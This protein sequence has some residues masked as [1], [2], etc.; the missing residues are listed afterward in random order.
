MAQPCQ[1]TGQAW[2]IVL[3]HGPHPG[4]LDIFPFLSDLRAGLYQ[5]LTD[6]AIGTLAHET[7]VIVAVPTADGRRHRQFFFGKLTQQFVQAVAAPAEATRE[8]SI[9]VYTCSLAAPVIVCAASRVKLPRN[10]DS[11]LSTYCSFSPAA[12]TTN[13]RR[14]AYCGD[15]AP[16]RAIGP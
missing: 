1:S 15:A 2:H 7:Q 13:R 12:T 14:R 8:W 11:A 4:L 5:V 16:G 9:S 6:E 10:T 3:V